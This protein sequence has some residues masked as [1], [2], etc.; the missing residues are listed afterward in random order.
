MRH[1]TAG[2]VA[3]TIGVV[4]IAAVAA[5]RLF[6]AA[7]AFE[8]VS[9]RVRPTNTEAAYAAIRTDIGA[10]AAIGNEFGAKGTTVLA[11]AFH[12]TQ[13]QIALTFAAQFPGTAKGVLAL[14]KITSDLTNLV[15]TLDGER[16]RFDRADSIPTSSRSSTAVPWFI[17]VCGIVGLGIGVGLMLGIRGSV[18][19]AAALGVVLI[20]A[21]LATS[22]PQKASAADTMNDHL[23]P[24]FTQQNLANLRGDVDTLTAMGTELQTKLV[25][26]LSTALGVPAAQVTAFVGANFPVL[27][28]ALPGLGA[29]LQRLTTN[30]ATLGEIRTDF[31]ASSDPNLAPIAWTVLGGGIVMLL[32]AGYGMTEPQPSAVGETGYAWR[33]RRHAA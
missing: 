11:A 18:W 10:L 27:S 26:T 33:R 1:R 8:R 12:Q 23:R 15:T 28:Q 22:L 17:L 29:G 32:F 5:S 4:L 19:A 31:L 24:V 9:E 25:P 2:V 7:N 14:P 3:F 21:P 16:A 13:A 30:I 20:A 6:G